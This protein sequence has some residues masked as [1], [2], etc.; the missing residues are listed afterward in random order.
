MVVR[1]FEREAPR[2]R[3]QPVQR[4]ADGAAQRIAVR[5]VHVERALRTARFRERTEVRIR[6]V[7]PDVRRDVETEIGVEHEHS[8]ER[9]RQRNVRSRSLAGQRFERVVALRVR[10]DDADARAEAEVG[11]FVE[12]RHA[13]E[14]QTRRVRLVPAAAV[15]HLRLALVDRE[16]GAEQE[17]FRDERIEARDRAVVAQVV[18]RALVL[19]LGSVGRAADR[20]R[21]GLDRSRGF[22]ERAVVAAL[23]EA[24]AQQVVFELNQSRRKLEDSR[25]GDRREIAQLRGLLGVRAGAADR[26][27]DG[28]ARLRRERRVKFL[29]A[30]RDDFRRRSHFRNVDARAVVADPGG[31]LLARSVEELRVPIDA[32]R[33]VRRND[34]DVAGKIAVERHFRR[35]E[36]ECVAR[37]VNRGRALRGNV[38]EQ[39]AR[40][41]QVALHHARRLRGNGGIVRRRDTQRGNR[42]EFARQVERRALFDVEAGRH[43]RARAERERRARRHG[44]RRRRIAE[45]RVLRDREFAVFEINRARARHGLFAQRGKFRRRARRVAQRESRVRAAGKA[46][47]AHGRRVERRR[48][49]HETADLHVDRSRERTG[50]VGRAHRL[51]GVRDLKRSR[52]GKRVQRSRVVLRD[53]QRAGN[54]HASR[55]AEARV[56]AEHRR[57]VLVD[58]HVAAEIPVEVFLRLRGVHVLHVSRSRDESHFARAGK[59]GEIA[60]RHVRGA[61]LQNRARG[62]PHDARL[63][64][65][66]FDRLHLHR[67]AARD[68]EHA[69][70]AQRRTAE[71]EIA[72]RNLQAAVAQVAGVLARAVNRNLHAGKRRV[73]REREVEHAALRRGV[74]RGDQ[75]DRLRNQLGAVGLHR[76]AG[77]DLQRAR[78]ARVLEIQLR[79]AGRGDRERAFAREPAPDRAVRAAEIGDLEHAFRADGKRLP[80]EAVI[81]F[82]RQRAAVRIDRDRRA[83]R[84]RRVE[85]RV[86]ERP[87]AGTALDDVARGNLRIEDRAFA[88]ADEHQLARDAVVP[89]ERAVDG[90]LRLRRIMREAHDRAG[91]ARELRVESRLVAGGAAD[92]RA[93]SVELLR[94]FQRAVGDA[95]LRSRRHARERERSRGNARLRRNLAADEAHARRL[96]DEQTVARDRTLENPGGDFHRRVLGDRDH[97]RAQVAVRRQL[98]RAGSDFEPAREIRARGVDV[99]PAPVADVQ[100]DRSRAGGEGRR[101]HVDFGNVVERS[102]RQIDEERRIRVLRRERDRADGERFLA[103]LVHRE[104]SRAR[105]DDLAGEFLAQVGK[106]ARVS[107]DRAR[108]DDR[109]LDF[110]VREPREAQRRGSAREPDRARARRARVAGDDDRSRVDESIPVL[111]RSDF[112][113]ENAVREIFQ[114][115]RSREVRVR[116]DV[117][118]GIDAVHAAHAAERQRSRAGDRQRRRA[119]HVAEH[120]AADFKRSRDV[121]HVARAGKLQRVRDEIAFGDRQRSVFQKQLAIRVGDVRVVVQHAAVAR[122]DDAR[123]GGRNRV[124]ARERQRIARALDDELAL[125]ARERSRHVAVSGVDDGRRADLRVLARHDDFGALGDRKLR[126]AERA[127]ARKENLAFRRGRRSREGLRGRGPHAQR[128]RA[129]LFER[130]RARKAARLRARVRFERQRH[131]AR[132]SQFGVFRDRAEETH[133]AFALQVQLHVVAESDPRE[134]DAGILARRRDRRAGFVDFQH[135]ARFGEPRVHDERRAVGERHRVAPEARDVLAHGHRRVGGETERVVDVVRAVEG[136][137]LAG[138]L[139]RSR[140]REL[141]VHRQRARVRILQRKRRSLADDGE[142]RAVAVERAERAARRER[143]RRIRAHDHVAAQI[144]RAADVQR[145]ARQLQFRGGTDRARDLERSRAE[146]AQHEIARV[147]GVH[148][149]AFNLQRRILVRDAHKKSRDVPV[150]VG[151]PDQRQIALDRRGADDVFA[152]RVFGDDRRRRNPLAVFVDLLLV[153]AGTEVAAV[154]EAHRR[155]VAGELDEIQR[156]RIA[157]ERDALALRHDEFRVRGERGVRLE[158]QRGGSGGVRD[159]DAPDVEVVCGDEHAALGDRQLVQLRRAGDRERAR[160]RLLQRRSRKRAGKRHA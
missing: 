44:E 103:G 140:D 26:A 88:A 3:G 110:L 23:F 39:L 28:A 158:G 63:R 128:S 58:P 2:L 77:A 46:D 149:S 112:G 153:A 7:Q 32:R 105:R 104:R 122:A 115:Q 11:D 133:F 157:P 106:H 101:A 48:R 93:R 150:G 33:A 98:E 59:R 73:A 56:A 102:S 86:R 55:V 75:L 159:F 24:L 35:V 13:V 78:P 160:A 54:R 113:A 34:D 127:A 81:G 137:F 69:A 41:R 116:I 111:R 53:A 148:D 16:R 145:A 95:D 139:K 125:A 108:A 118:F 121:D 90:R 50:R 107:L 143:K 49:H 123:E 45:R 5:L 96:L 8:A 109:R 129:E 114:R 152:H 142:K 99:E 38:R 130:T 144:R 100:R 43:R 62:E 89:R 141:R 61:D 97:R 31:E 36:H 94:E 52:A 134:D 120:R 83:R 74:R 10:A 132:Q 64:R 60:L 25:E 91:A 12:H 65:D 92:E 67:G 71:I 47:F 68:V 87:L 126:L 147:A 27:E 85:R 154:L 4:R 30:A 22:V 82:E 156:R 37:R 1:E 18:V 124:R 20:V 84:R 155:V 6:V 21:E 19:A 117:Q 66:A 135:A 57:R 42:R 131:A 14:V 15:V 80:V 76:R 72:A 146:L 40:D 151:V 119:L 51:G 29:H 138:D 136:N 17:V 9:R 79:H 70:E